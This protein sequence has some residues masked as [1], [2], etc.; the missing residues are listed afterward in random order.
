MVE[1]RIQKIP[2]IR[3]RKYLEENSDIFIPPLKT[4]IDIETFSN[5]IYTNAIHICAFDNDK[6]IGFLAS[7]FNHPQN[8]FGY[9]TTISVSHEYQNK[10]IAS[11]L[12]IEAFS[13]ARLNN[14]NRIRLEVHKNNLRA[15]DFYKMKGFDFI[16]SKE[17][18]FIMEA[19]V[20]ANNF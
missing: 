16:E 9:I 7:Y 19:K 1:I 13:Y 14:F 6:L 4:R 18:S 11:K 5:K 12:L 8:E 17:F 10:G 2:Q 3:I 15:I 20:L